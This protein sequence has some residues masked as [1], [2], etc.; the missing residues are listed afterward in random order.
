MLKS[1]LLGKCLAGSNYSPK[2]LF[3]LAGSNYSPKTT[4]YL[5]GSNY[6]PKT[7]S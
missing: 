5:A 1:Q 2:T 6:S 3:Y 7:T 4:F